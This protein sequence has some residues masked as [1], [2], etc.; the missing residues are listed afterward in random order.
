MI[1]WVFYDI[2]TDYDNNDNNILNWINAFSFLGQI[3]MYQFVFTIG[4]IVIIGGTCILFYIW[5]I[6]FIEEYCCM[7]T[8]LYFVSIFLYG[9]GIFLSPLIM[10]IVNYIAPAVILFFLIDDLIPS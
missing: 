9:V 7:G 6:I 8:F 5:L 10:E 4:L 1:S 3:W 2:N